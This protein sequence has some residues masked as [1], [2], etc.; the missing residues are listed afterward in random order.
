M[1]PNAVGPNSGHDA[2][3]RASFRMI[4]A[5]RAARRMRRRRRL[6]VKCVHDQFGQPDRAQKMPSRG[7]S[8]VGHRVA[9]PPARQTI[10][11]AAI[12]P[13]VSIG[14]SCGDF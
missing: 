8:Q 6:R 4:S 12:A 11:I 9:R 7:E 2:R 10:L 5:G 3:S 13:C 14:A 1:M